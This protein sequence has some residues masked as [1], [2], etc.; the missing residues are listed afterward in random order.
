MFTPKM[1]NHA[2]TLSLFSIALKA[3]DRL[4]LAFKQV[5]NAGYKF[6]VVD[7]TRGRCYFV[8]KVITIPD[9]VLTKRRPEYFHWYLAHELSHALA[10][11]QA[12]H[13][14]AFQRQLLAICP[15]ESIQYETNYKRRNA[16]RAQ[17]AAGYIPDDLL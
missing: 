1:V 3:P 15:P 12:K 13:G 5:K 9:W 6:Y 2:L 11:Y 8:Q 17:I 10:G 14:E 4:A 7:Q 16:A